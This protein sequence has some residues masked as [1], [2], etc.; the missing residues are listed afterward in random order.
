MDKFADS[1]DYTARLAESED[2]IKIQESFHSGNE[3]IDNDFASSEFDR[4]FVNYV[5]TDN[6][7]NDIIACY[8]LGCSACIYSIYNKSY[9]TPAIEIAL[10]AVNEKYQDIKTKDGCECLSSIIFYELLSYISYLTDEVIGANKIILYATPNAVP[11]YTKCGF[12]V[13]EENMLQ[14]QDRFLDGCTAMY[15]DIK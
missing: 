1:I 14:N 2:Y 13:F 11:F 10:F 9:F 5:V 4:R 8:A 6:E 7:T 12:G 15:I 3:V